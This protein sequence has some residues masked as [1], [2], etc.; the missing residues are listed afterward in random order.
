MAMQIRP[1]Y[2]NPLTTVTAKT[3]TLNAS[4]PFSLHEGQTDKI[5]ELQTKQQSLQN[6]MLLFKAAGTDSAGTE[7]EHLTTEELKKVTAELR[8]AKASLTPSSKNGKDSYEPEKAGLI[9]PGLYQV[10]E[11]KEG[12]KILFS[13]FS[14]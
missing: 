14:E 1:G 6:R 9:S 4:P 7:M 8:N 10:K 12:Y 5:I 11:H 3:R 2:I 13:P